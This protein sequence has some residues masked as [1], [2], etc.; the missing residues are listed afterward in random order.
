MMVSAQR[1]WALKMT[2]IICLFTQKSNLSQNDTS[3]LFCAPECEKTSAP[4]NLY[5]HHHRTKLTGFKINQTRYGINC[6]D[7]GSQ[8]AK[9]K[10]HLF[11]MCHAE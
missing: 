4:H 5:G 10:R 11:L 6:L 8:S 1:R 2:V 9:K 7:S 3:V